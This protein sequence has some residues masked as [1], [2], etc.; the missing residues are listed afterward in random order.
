M[1][2]MFT[3]EA[4]RRITGDKSSMGSLFR[5]SLIEAENIFI[6]NQTGQNTEGPK[7]GSGFAVVPGGQ[8]RGDTIISLH[9]CLM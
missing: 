9:F 8:E 3:K 4:K 1:F 6:L 7:T 2:N 5:E